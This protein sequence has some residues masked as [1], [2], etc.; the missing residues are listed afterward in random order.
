M[1]TS[2]TNAFYVFK[3]DGTYIKF[4]CKQNGLYCLDV[5]DRSDLTNLLTTVDDQNNYSPNLMCGRPHKQDTFRT[6]YVYHLTMTW[7]MQL[8]KV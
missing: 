1:D 5:N 7:Q 4:E 2:V 6:V 8:K 3:D